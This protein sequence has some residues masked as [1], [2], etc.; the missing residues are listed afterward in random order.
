V[1]NSPRF[2]PPASLLSYIARLLFLF[3]SCSAGA[4][5]QAPGYQRIIPRSVAEVQSTVQSLRAT[6]SGRLPTLEGFVQDTDAPLERFDRGY[7]ECTFKVSPAVGG[8]TMVQATAKITAWYTDPLPARSGY[9]VLVSNGR[10]ENDALDRIEQ[11]VAPG[12]VPAPAPVPPPP[13]APAANAGGLRPSIHLD[14]QA[15]PADSGE[16]TSLGDSS[17]SPSSA[18]PAYAPAAPAAPLPS[19]LSLDTLKAER[20]AAQKQALDLTAY[21][22]N[23]EEIL[24]NQS[25]P[26]DLVAVKRP[27]TPIFE[28]PA[29]DSAVLLHA[30]AQD[31]FQ[32]LGVEGSWVH[33]QISGAARGWMRRSQLE[34]PP[35]YA[36]EADPAGAAAPPSAPIFKLAKEETTPFSG[37]WELLKGKTVRIEWIEPSVPS[38]TSSAAEKLAFA[39][40]VFLKSYASL[41]AANQSVEGVVVVF[42]S[43]DGGQIA[44][45]ISSVKALADGSLSASAFWRRCSLDP[46]ES[47]QDSAK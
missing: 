36:Q 5:A 32:I 7:Y 4:A 10:L 9:R 28:R 6:F 35:G 13:A 16:S 37:N 39:K 29:E 20:E 33:V 30:E 24:H 12:S 40:S 14:A 18:S 19:G 15:A 22:K 25:R 34:M 46:P 27:K 43:A 1:I 26:V 41:L 47:F 38:A 31:E 45:T 8:G 23:L 42:D 2:R 11:A 17:S 44:A 21:V 3:L